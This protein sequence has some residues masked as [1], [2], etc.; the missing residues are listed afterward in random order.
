M[1]EP[2]NPPADDDGKRHAERDAEKI[3]DHVAVL[4]M[5]PVE[6]GLRGLQSQGEAQ[7]EKHRNGKVTPRPDKEGR[8]ERQW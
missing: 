4:Q 2:A 1:A 3:C 5:M 6:R 7:R 8:E